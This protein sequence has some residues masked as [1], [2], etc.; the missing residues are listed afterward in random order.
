M[1]FLDPKKQRR[2]SFMLYLGYV[3]I[4][5]AGTT[6]V[7]LYEAY[8]FGLGKGGTVIQNGLIYLSSQP[9][10][11]N[12]SVNGKLQSNSTNTALTLPEGIYNVQLTKSGYRTWDRNIE[13]DGGTIESFT[14]PLLI[15]SKLTTTSV[16]S[17]S[18]QPIL[19]TQSLNRKTLL[20][21]QPGSSNNFDLY[22]MTNP[23]LAPTHISLPSNILSSPSSSESWQLISWA[24][25]NQHVLLNHIFDGKNEYVLFD[26]NDPTKSVNLSQT[27]SGVSYTSISL[28]NFAYDKYYLFNSSGG[29]LMTDDL[30]SPTNPTTILNN[31]ISYDTYNGNTVLYS[32]TTG[33]AAGKVNIDILQGQDNYRIKTFNAG[34]TYLLNMAGYNSSVYVV[35]GASNEDKVY[36]YNDP[37]GQIHSS[38]KQAPVPVQVLFL[39]NPTYVN[40]SASAQFVMAESGTHFA[41]FNIQNSSGYNYVSNLPLDS[42]QTNATWMDG[43]RITYVSGGKLVTFEFDHNYVQKLMPA[44]SNYL[45]FFTPNYNSVYSLA[46][47]SSPNTNLTRTSLYTSADQ[48]QK[49]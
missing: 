18:T 7:L 45:P 44:D 49:L 35:A 5:V 6:L 38:P 27:L 22:D 8:G 41:V 30:N 34:S 32:T 13:V 20:I 28:D 1:D 42:P 36:I 48:P 9:N 21:Q 16:K 33:A 17:Y 19:A 24:N 46:P 31:V 12:V 4:V 3:L 23:S 2:H 47:G 26:T 11:A 29:V 14:Y 10:P 39:D 40:F 15:P 43:D 37:I 25:D